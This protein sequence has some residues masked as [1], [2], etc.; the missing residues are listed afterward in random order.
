MRTN[1]GRFA[2]L[3]LNA[4]GVVLACLAIMSL[5]DLLH[6]ANAELARIVG[7]VPPGQPAWVTGFGMAGVLLLAGFI[8]ADR[9][10]E[11]LGL[12]LMTLGVFAQAITAYAYI[13]V[14]EFTTTRF[15]LVVVLALCTWARMSVLWSR[16]GLTV[17]IPARGETEEQ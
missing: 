15:G 2:W 17:R 13:G 5:T 3:R 11:S 9:M 10:A 1:G 6:P 8:R 14:T 12:L 4:Y 7:D 16:R